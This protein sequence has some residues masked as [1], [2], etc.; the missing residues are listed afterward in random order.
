[1]GVIRSRGLNSTFILKICVTVGALVLAVVHRWVPFILDAPTIVL[2]VIALLP[3]LQPLVKSVELLG[4]KLE[5][6]DLQDKVAAATG[7]AE[8]AKQKAFFAQSASES[9]ISGT[10]RHLPLTGDASED[11]LQAL[12]DKYDDIRDTQSPGDART[13]AMTTVVHKIIELAPH[14]QGFNLTSALVEKKRGVRLVAYAILYAV[15]T[16][17]LL[18]ALVRSV[19]TIEDK[20]FG[21]YWGLQAIARVIDIVPSIS[22]LPSQ[23]ITQLREFG[24]RIPRGTDRDYELRQVLEALRNKA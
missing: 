6:Q 22:K 10:P 11:S 21:Q 1:M 24:T 18:E 2:L 12:A 19:T 17:A 20:P 15:P 4:V 8:S 23:V 3:W 13:L 5:L 16:R 7:A 14:S 9:P